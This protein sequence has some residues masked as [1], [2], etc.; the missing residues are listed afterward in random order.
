[1]LWKKIEA[2]FQK[3]GQQ[4]KED[5]IEPVSYL[6]KGVLAGSIFLI[7]FLIFYWIFLHGKKK[8]RI[9]R[10]LMVAL[11][12]VYMVVL[13]NFAFFSRE[14]G[15]RVGIDWELFE[16]W[17]TSISSQSYVIENIIMFIP[18]GVLFPAGMPIF[19]KI[20]VCIPTGALFSIF[21]EGMQ[22]VT[23]RGYCQLDDIATN[24]LG[25]IIG[26]V[27]FAI[28]YYI[29]WRGLILGSVSC[30]VKFIKSHNR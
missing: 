2:F 21:L 16:T 14:P 12:V 15:S 6:P 10:L 25:T 20:W 27:L 28:W 3:Y 29:L 5:M 18:F 19:R 1:M 13:W 11:L 7:S 30:I 4:L 22:L 24:T 23:K 17:G 8:I 9:K 26:W